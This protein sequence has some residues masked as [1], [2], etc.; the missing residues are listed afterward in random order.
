MNLRV[1]LIQTDIFWENKAANLASFEQKIASLAGKTMVVVLPEMFSTGFSMNTQLLAE[2]MD[3]NTIQWMQ[4]V[5]QLYRVILAGSVIIEENGRYFNRF[6]WMLPNGQLGFYDKRHLFA[7]AGEHQH[8]T[9]GS[10]RFIARVNGWRINCQICFDLRF[11]VWARQQIDKSSPNNAEYDVLIYVANWPEK[12]NH[13]W[14]SLLVARAI[15]NQCFVIGVNRVG[16][17][18]N[19]L[20]YAGNSM[21]V[22]PMGEILN[23]DNT[24]ESCIITEVLSQSLLQNTRMQIPFLADADDF[25]IQLS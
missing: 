7:Y 3:G 18:G 21:V 11:P 24:H 9:P 23:P 20:S 22:N 1:S 14:R 2:P 13:A 6:I 10:K 15:E 12:R 8:F 5:S 4:K 16:T 19:D 25:L 17:D